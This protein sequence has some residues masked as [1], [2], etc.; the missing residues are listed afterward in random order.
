M[1][2]LSKYKK[3]FL[4]RQRNFL[5]GNCSV[6]LYHRVDSLTS[7]RN[8]LAIT[9]DEFYEQMRFLKKQ[10]N[11]LEVEEFD[12]LR[13]KEKRF[14]DRSILISFDDGYRDNDLYARPILESLN[15]Q[16][17]FL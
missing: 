11:I 2:A 17:L 7:D 3:L 16:A 1:A 15:L 9:P 8:Q 12:Y 10:F 4:R 13:S 14:P 6:L 5:K